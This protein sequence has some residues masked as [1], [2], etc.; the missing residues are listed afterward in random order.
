MASLAMDGSPRV[1]TL[2]FRDWSSA[3][4]LDLLT[5][6][7]S[8]KC[9]EL[10]IAPPVELCWLLRKSHEQFRL[11][12]SA[13]LITTPVETVALD[14]HWNRLS[15]AGRSV[16]AWPFPGH[17]FEAQGSWPEEVSEQSVIPEH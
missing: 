8:H 9:M 17:P 3:D 11:R 2:V 5:H 13:K 12:G 1:R 7:R 10:E 15:P 4:V 14:H 6:A 16:W